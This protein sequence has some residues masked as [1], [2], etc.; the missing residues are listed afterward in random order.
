MKSCRLLC[1]AQ[2]ATTEVA[3]NTYHKT[4]RMTLPISTIGNNVRTAESGQPIGEGPLCRAQRSKLIRFSHRRNP[5]FLA[6]RFW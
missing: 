4:L 3:G 1:I 6:Y 2:A 5:P